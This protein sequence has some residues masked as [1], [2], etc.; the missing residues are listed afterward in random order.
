MNTQDMLY[1]AHGHPLIGHVFNRNGA[2]ICACTSCTFEGNFE[3]LKSH[4]ALHAITP[5]PSST[6]STG[7]NVSSSP[8]PPVPVSVLLP[9]SSVPP[10]PTRKN[11]CL[12]CKVQLATDKTYHKHQKS[13]G[14]MKKMA[15]KTGSSSYVPARRTQHRSQ[16]I[17]DKKN[18]L[19]TVEFPLS[20]VFQN[21][22]TMKM[23]CLS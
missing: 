19:K 10:P 16:T 5:S 17:Y 9:P 18:C 14:H 11:Y 8:P 20:A 21:F 2:L 1:N 15:P 12:V 13:K 4:M 23:D 3:D 7:S 22:N 6:A